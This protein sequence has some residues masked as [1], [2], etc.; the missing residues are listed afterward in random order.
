MKTF[1][2]AYAALEAAGTEQT[3]K[4]YQR[5]GS[6]DNL[7]GVSFTNL[8]A[9]KNKIIAA[10]GSTIGNHPMAE[11]LWGTGNSDACILACMVANPDYFTSEDAERWVKDIHYHVVADYFTQLIMQTNFAEELLDAWTRSKD[12]FKLRS[13]YSLLGQ[14]ALNDD[15]RPDSFFQAYIERCELDLQSSPNR[16]KESMSNCLIAIGCRN[17]LLRLR[18]IE[19]SRQ[20]G[21]VVIDHGD[22]ACQSIIIEDYLE[23][24]HMRKEKNTSCRN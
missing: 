10:R 11:Q 6:G 15:T 8:K 24:M 23:K 13:G 22:M 16:A 7:F 4:I 19:A 18:V 14:V 20:I 5:N 1:K 17:D 21:E 2:E 12:E 9:F 3:R